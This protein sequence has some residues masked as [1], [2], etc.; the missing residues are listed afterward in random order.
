MGGEAKAKSSKD[1]GDLVLGG[2]LE[3]DKKDYRAAF[4]ADFTRK[5][6][7]YPFSDDEINAFIDA[8]VKS[9][10]KRSEIDYTVAQYMPNSIVI[11][12]KPRTVSLN[13]T[14]YT[15]RQDFYDKHRSEYGSLSDVYKATDKSYANDMMAGMD[16][17]PLLTP[18]RDYQL[19]FVKTDGKWV[20]ERD[21]SYESIV[22]A[23]EGDIS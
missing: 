19:K 9:N 7:D 8:Y 11:K 6:H 18:E 3:Q 15:Y 1:K 21:Y 17:R 20:L 2:D 22:R 16:S 4:A 13:K 10:A 12:I 23:F 14:M 5:L